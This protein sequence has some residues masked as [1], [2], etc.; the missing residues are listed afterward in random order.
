MGMLF[1]GLLFVIMQANN[2]Y[3]ELI[4]QDKITATEGHS[5][6]FYCFVHPIDSL[7]EGKDQ[8]LCII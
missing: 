3:L 1:S 6:Y 5:K 2:W 4:C 7:T 8:K